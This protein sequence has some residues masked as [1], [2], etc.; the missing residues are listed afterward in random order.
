MDEAFEPVP[1]QDR[2]GAMEMH[3][4]CQRTI[5]TDD[6]VAVHGLQI[7]VVFDANF[8]SLQ[9]VQEDGFKLTH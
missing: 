2:L 5:V 9:N 1:T 6:G 8:E 4:A 7:A 3:D